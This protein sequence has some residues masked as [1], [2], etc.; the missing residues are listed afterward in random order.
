VSTVC[1]PPGSIAMRQ[2]TTFVHGPADSFDP[3]QLHV[4]P[5]AV[6][7][8][9]LNAAREDRLT[10]GLYELPQEVLIADILAGPTITNYVS[11]GVY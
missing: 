5:N 6:H 2:R 9:S 10:F 8:E 4:E 7:I 11:Y 1:L 3:K